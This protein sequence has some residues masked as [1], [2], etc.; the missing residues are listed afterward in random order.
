MKKVING[1]M[2]NTD[3]AESIAYFDNDRYSNDYY[4][5]CARL[6]RKKTGEFFVHD[7]RGWYSQDYIGYEN[8]YQTDFD[9][10]Q[11][12]YPLTEDEA[13]RLVASQCDGDKYQSLFGTVEE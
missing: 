13:K 10:K 4:F 8:Y 6:Y 3:T 11:P 2:Y 5:T 9:P 12:I 1:K 7:E